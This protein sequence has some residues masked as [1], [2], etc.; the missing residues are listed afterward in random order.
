MGE[1]SAPAL[2]AGWTTS[3]QPPFVARHEEVAALEEAWADTLGGA[4]RAVFISGEPGSGK[5]RLVSEVCTRLHD[6]GA[7]VLVGAVHP[8]ARRAVRAL[9][10]AAA[11]AAASL[12]GAVRRMPPTLESAELLAHVLARTEAGRRS[13]GR[14]PGAR[15]PRRDRRAAEPRRRRVPIVL[16]LEDLHWAGPAAMRLLGR[17]VEGDRRRQVLL[18]R[19]APRA[20]RPIGRTRSPTRSRRSRGCSGVQRTR[21]RAPSP[22]TRSPTTSRSARAL[23][24]R[25]P[26]SAEVLLELTGGNPFLLRAMWRPVVEAER[27]ATS[28]SSS[29]PTPSA[30]SCARASR[31]SMT[32]QRSVLELAAVL[33]QEVDLSEVIGISAASVD[34]TLDAMDAAVARRPHR[35]AAQAAA[36]CYRFPHAIARQAVID[37]DARARR[38]CARMRASRRRSRPTSPPRPGSSS[39]SRTITPPRV[40]SGSATAPSPTWFEPPSSRRIAYAYEDAARLFER[41]SEITPDADERAELLL[42]PRTAGTWRRDTPRARTLYEQVTGQSGN[43]R[44]RLRAAIGYE[45][46]SWRPGLLGHRALELLSTALASIPP[47]EDDPLFIEAL[48]SLARATAF[49]GADRRGRAHRRSRG[50]A[51]AG[52]WRSARAHRRAPLNASR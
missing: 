6:G 9:R 41:A 50:R 7:A 13:T 12:P 19:H 36:T 51:R 38:S 23:A 8:G 52:A 33:G 49:T 26:R 11:R 17:V 2:P 46:A 10:P 32:V 40:R 34:V 5:S 16:V 29:C 43:P 20:R 31:C 25:C 44:Q 39:V 30:T 35:A 24:R 37:V 47:D 45:D 4:G 1:W 14:R 22:P 27:Q 28:A 18:H 48:G 21:A 15:V 3:G 42:R